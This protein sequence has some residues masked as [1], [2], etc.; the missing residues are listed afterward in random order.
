MKFEYKNKNIA[1][2]IKK[3]WKNKKQKEEMLT[4]EYLIPIDNVVSFGRTIE[5]KET[6]LRNLKRLID[7]A[8]AA[9]YLT[10]FDDGAGFKK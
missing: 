1:E 7:T 5:E 4:G 3:T 6:I 2:L 9:G 10:G 8:Q